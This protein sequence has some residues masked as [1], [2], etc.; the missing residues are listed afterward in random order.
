MIY[1][2]ELFRE[3]LGIHIYGLWI[4]KKNHLKYFLAKT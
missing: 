2:T 4:L 3:W 1:S